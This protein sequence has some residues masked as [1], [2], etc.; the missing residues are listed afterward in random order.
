MVRVLFFASFREQLN[1]R[2]VELE[3]TDTPCSVA[4]LMGRLIAR[5]SPVAEHDSPRHCHRCASPDR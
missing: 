1:T 3:L 2:Q 4:D 5:P